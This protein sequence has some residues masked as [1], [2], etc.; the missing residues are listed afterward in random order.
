MEIRVNSDLNTEVL[1]INKFENEMTSQELINTYA[2]EK[3]NFEGKLG[4][5]YLLHTYGK[6]S[7]DKILV[8]GFGK[9]EEFDGAK[10]TEAVVKAMKKLKQIK[11]KRAVFDFDR[12]QDYGKYAALC[13]LILFHC[14]YRRSYQQSYSL[15]TITP[16]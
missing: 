5:T 1:V 11:A 16:S 6:I 8:V 12:V 14:E 2:I 15:K 10:M 13:A 9:K 7:A 4:T 3:D